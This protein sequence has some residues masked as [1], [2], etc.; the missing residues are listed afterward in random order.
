MLMKAGRIGTLIFWALAIAG[1]ATLL[2]GALSPMMRD[3]GILILLAHVAE[4]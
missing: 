1:A 3:L 2:P 4:V